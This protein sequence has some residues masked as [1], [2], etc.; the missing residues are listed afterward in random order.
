MHRP[1]SKI[2]NRDVQSTG[3][4]IE[5]NVKEPGRIKREKDTIYVLMRMYCHDKHHTKEGLCESCGDL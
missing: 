2:E 4:M 3:E 1:A 5:N